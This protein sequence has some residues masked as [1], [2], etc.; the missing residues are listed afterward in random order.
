M[1]VNQSFEE[2]SPS[3]LKGKKI[4][5]YGASTRNKDMIDVLGIKDNIMFCVDSNR[6][7]AGK[8]QNNYEIKTLECLNA[9]E[10]V[11]VVSVLDYAYAQILETLS[12]YGINECVFY[13]RECFDIDNVIN[14]NREVINKHIRYRYIH[15]FTNDKF[16]KSFYQMIE[17]RFDIEEHLFI[18]VYRFK[19]DFSKLYKYAMMKNQFNNNILVFD[20]VHGIAEGVKRLIPAYKDCNRI[21]YGSECKALYENADRIILHSALFGKEEFKYIK[22]LVKEYEHKMHLVFWGADVYYDGNSEIVQSVIK[23]VKSTYT[24]QTGVIQVKKEYNIDAIESNVTYN[25]ISK[26]TE[27]DDKI[28]KCESC[29]NILLGHSAAEYSNHEKGFE[30]LNEYKNKDIR[31]YSPMSYGID[32]YRKKVISKGKEIFG[33]KFIPITEFMEL[34]EYIKFIEK[35]DIAI[36]P[37]KRMAATTTIKYLDAFGKKIYMTKDMAEHYKSL[38]IEIND[39]AKLDDAS[40]VKCA[41]RLDDIY[42]TIDEMNENVVNEWKKIIQ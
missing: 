42:Y 12:N 27:S 32:E 25:Y 16:M 1:L 28:S 5:I 35:I 39:I 22:W 17:E 10:N 4:I 9:V 41:N 11:Q 37:L 2:I 29:V 20:D 3:L 14:S 23:R 36:L 40:F 19:D 24:V 15:I 31:I 6:E 7:N 34:D 33:D 38:N 21:L 13:F 18:L 8:K 30:I 26:K